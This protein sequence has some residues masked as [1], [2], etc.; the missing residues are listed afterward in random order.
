MNGRNGG[1]R[2][3]R[4]TSKVPSP[5]KVYLE[6]RGGVI[7]INDMSLTLSIWSIRKKQQ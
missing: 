7:I 3:S 5:H 4:F 2:P 6:L 1:D